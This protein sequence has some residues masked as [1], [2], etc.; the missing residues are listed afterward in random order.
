MNTLAIDAVE[1]Y[2]LEL[3][4]RI[5]TRLAALDARG[6]FREDAWQRPEGGGGRTRV[7][8]EGRV[9]E[10]A[11]VNFSKV[12][13]VS[14]PPSASAHRP[15]LAGRRFVAMGMSLELARPCRKT[16]ISST[17]WCEMNNRLCTSPAV[18]P[19]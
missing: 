3:Q 8:A 11:G 12:N 10:K 15:E 2:L 9:F 16:R 7:L 4:E 13:G 17:S 19:K 5:C 6:A 1:H 18:S 14:L